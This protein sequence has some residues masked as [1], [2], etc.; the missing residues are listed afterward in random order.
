M[1][2]AVALLT[3]CG[4]TE[5]ESAFGAVAG[6]WTYTEWVFEDSQTGELRDYLTMRVASGALEIAPDSSFLLEEFAL[7][8]G[9]E[10]HARLTGTVDLVEGFSPSLS[11]P[12][13]ADTA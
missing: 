12:G 3:G 10:Y 1:V 4:A 2:A 7:W 5:P 8:V 6:R 13:S 9:G 11:H